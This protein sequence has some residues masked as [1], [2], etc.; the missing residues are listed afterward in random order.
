METRAIMQMENRHGNGKGETWTVGYLKSCD[1]AVL[2]IRQHRP[3]TI[4]SGKSIKK[5]Y[6]TPR[7][8][9][10]DER[11]D[12]SLTEFSGLDLIWC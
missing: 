10:G 3:N 6:S 2:P 11:S 1:L 9:Q 7:S 8:F 12:Q 5:S 4:L